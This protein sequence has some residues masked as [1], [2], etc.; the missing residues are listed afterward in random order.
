MVLQMT[1]KS[2]H[3][4]VLGFF[5]ICMATFAGL[6]GA[7]ADIYVIESTASGVGVGVH[8]AMEDTV[9]IPAGA[10]IRA[11]LPS[12]KTQTIRG[13]YNGKVADLAK[14]VAQNEGVMAWLRNV[15][16]TGGH[17]EN[18]TGATRSVTGEGKPRAFSWVEVPTGANANVCVPKGQ[19]VVLTR[20][21]A[22]RADRASLVDVASGDRAEVVWEAGSPT[23]AWPA[24]IKLRPAGTYQVF[25]QDKQRKQVVLH[26]LDK[27][28]DDGDVLTELHKLG[29]QQ[30]FEAWVRERMTANKS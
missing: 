18:T 15:L 11:V 14:G 9:A 24:N 28:P 8:L 17:T 30:Q 25:V 7:R 19:K 20:T 1:K 29:C 4:L 10:Y 23:A 3:S 13:P 22:G 2:S 6:T 12:G 16:K 21:S 27:L 5:A 26:V